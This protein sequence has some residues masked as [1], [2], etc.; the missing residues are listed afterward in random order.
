MIHHMG[1]NTFG[2][3]GMLFGGLLII[4]LIIGIIL[5]VW[6]VKSVTGSKKVSANRDEKSPLEI[7]KLR[8]AKGK[9]AREEYLALL[10]DLE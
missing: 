8:Y 9:I 1:Y 4:G 3:G 6:V 7:V 5:I 2:W 10:A